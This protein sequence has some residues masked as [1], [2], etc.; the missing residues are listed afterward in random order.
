[1]KKFLF[2]IVAVLMA[3]PSF[4]QFSSGGFSLD[5]EHLYWGV[6]FGIN[7]SS[8]SGDLKADEG[9]AVNSA[10]IANKIFFITINFLMI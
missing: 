5:E 6:R 1:M 9:A 2:T 10:T 4:A 7:F 3:A 8:I